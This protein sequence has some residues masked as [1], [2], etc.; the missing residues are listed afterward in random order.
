MKHLNGTHIKLSC[1]WGR[2]HVRAAASILQGEAHQGH[3]NTL[4][5]WSGR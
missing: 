4:R 2:C 5:D 1:A 3:A